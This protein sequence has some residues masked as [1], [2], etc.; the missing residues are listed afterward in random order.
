ML[1]LADALIVIG[2]VG[3]V[4]GVAMVSLAAGIA[5]AGLVLLL[6]ALAVGRRNGTSG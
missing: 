5:V 3:V 2:A 4:V 1:D 6:F